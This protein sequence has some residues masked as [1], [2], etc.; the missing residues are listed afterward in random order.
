MTIV[1]NFAAE[2][3]YTIERTCDVCYIE[4]VGL[5]RCRCDYNEHIYCP[6]HECSR[7]KREM[8]R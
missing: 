5:L 6:E 1:V 4:V 7:C 2:G 8:A 3:G